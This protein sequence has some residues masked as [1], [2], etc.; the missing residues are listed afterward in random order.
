MIRKVLLL[1]ASI[2]C[3]TALVANAQTPAAKPAPTKMHIK[4]MREKWKANKPKLTAC[5]KDAKSKGLT[6]DDRWFYLEDCMGK[7]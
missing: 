2:L 4:E 7:N 5:R 3:G 6:G 1:S